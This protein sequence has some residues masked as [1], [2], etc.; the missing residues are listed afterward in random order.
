MKCLSLQSLLKYA[1]R[2]HALAIVRCRYNMKN[3]C[4]QFHLYEEKYIML[5]QGMFGRLRP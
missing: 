1:L 4:L 5:P 2:H 3:K